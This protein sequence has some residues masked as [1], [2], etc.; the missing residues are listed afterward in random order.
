MKLRAILLGGSQSNNGIQIYNGPQIFEFFA[1]KSR[2][3]LNTENQKEK[4]IAW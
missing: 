4:C 3:Q 2:K 1:F